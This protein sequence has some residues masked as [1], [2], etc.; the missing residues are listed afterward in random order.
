MI[1][2]WISN[3]YLAQYWCWQ[4]EIKFSW[5]KMF[6]L[7]MFSYPSLQIVEELDNLQLSIISTWVFLKNNIRITLYQNYSSSF[8]DLKNF[9]FII[10]I[11]NLS[12]TRHLKALQNEMKVDTRMNY[13]C[14]KKAVQIVRSCHFP[15]TCM[16]LE[17]QIHKIF[18]SLPY[19]IKCLFS[20][21]YSIKSSK[22][23]A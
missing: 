19:S 3:T 7:H 23:E 22:V 14:L 6:H 9:L 2:A 15:H 20:Y 4:Q 5:T 12:A 16:E 1:P 13:P 17:R 21:T 8:N 10:I 18:L 11:D